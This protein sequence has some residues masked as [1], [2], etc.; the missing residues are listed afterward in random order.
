MTVNRIWQRIF[1]T[2]LVKTVDDFGV[3]GEYPSHPELLDFLAVAFR[4]G[5]AAAGAPPWSTRRLVRLIVTSETYRQSSTVR[6]PLAAR[7]PENRLLGRFPRQRLAAEEIRDQALFAAGLLSPKLGGPP[8]LPYQPA[9]LW[10]ERG[11]EGSNTRIYERSVGEAL[12][13]R[14]LYTFWKRTCPPP[15]MTLFD[16]PDR[17]TCSARRVVTN[18]PLQALAVMNDEQMLECAKLLAART[19][20]EAASTPDRLTLIYRRATGRTPGSTDLE[21]LERG[22]DTL[23]KRYTAAP[24]DAAAL[25]LQG[26]APIPA[27]LDKPELAAWMLI[28]N[29]VLNTDAALVRD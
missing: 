11:N 24:D 10:E 25:L 6:P 13:R 23:K 8:S 14:S 16:A 28:A 12:Y 9:G 18:T 3:Q 17:L 26:V 4:E 20:R 5:D 29:T 27:D 22:L 15:F 2:G 7:D 19:L 1:G 21:A